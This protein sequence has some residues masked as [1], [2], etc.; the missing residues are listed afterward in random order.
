MASGLQT[1]FSDLKGIWPIAKKRKW[2]IMIPWVIVTGIVFG[3]AFTITPLYETSTIISVDT[4]VQLSE[5]LQRLLG[6]NRRSALGR[7]G[8]LQSIYNE[9]TSTKYIIELNKELHLDQEPWVLEAAQTMAANLPHMTTDQIVLHL[10]QQQIQG[11]VTLTQA[12]GDQIRLRTVSADP[13]Q[14][15]AIANTLSDI[16]ISE[17]HKQ[18]LASIRSSQNFSDV[19]LQKYE[20][21]LQEKI[22]ERTQLEQD[23]LIVQLDEFIIAE[24]NRSEISA[25]IDQHNNEIDRLRE[26][27]RNILS[28]VSQNSSLATHSLTLENSLR[29]NELTTDLREELSDI[30][31]LM[32]RYIW[33]DPQLLSSKLRQ[34]Q[35]IGLIESEN[36]IMVNAQYSG[37]AAETRRLLAQL[38]NIRFNLDYL[39]SRV[40][41]LDSGLEELTDKMNLIPVYQANLNRIKQE[42]TTTTELRDRFKRQQASSSIS[43][44]LL[45]DISSS[46][47]RIVEPAKNPLMPFKPDKKQIVVMGFILGLIIGC[48][49]AAIVE[50]MDNSF[51]KVEEI[52]EELDLP[53]IGVAPRMPFLKK[54]ET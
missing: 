15:V 18:Q 40:Q 9:I 23:F 25:E 14:A 54:I 2:L 38:F 11:Q 47:F 28:R 7:P 52:T 19:Q 5:E 27:E 21:Q 17:K 45:Q 22:D 8:E 32:T 33:T 6:T 24:P 4:R 16:F 35:L 39:Y 51:K 30:T 50:L 10:L 3:G 53:V 36:R 34:N 37:E 1:S 49:A 43:Q 41:Y 46:K 29:H 44:A 31:D 12:A 20:L 26:D 13:E 48:A 42:I